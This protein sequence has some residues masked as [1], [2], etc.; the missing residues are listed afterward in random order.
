MN[1]STE[2]QTLQYMLFI[3]RLCY[4]LVIPRL[5]YPVNAGFCHYL[6]VSEI[7]YIPNSLM[8][9][10]PAQ[11]DRW[12]VSFWFMPGRLS[13]RIKLLKKAIKLEKSLLTQ[14]Q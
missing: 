13:P 12:S 9:F 8:N 14:N 11:E 2:L 5:C 6:F 10:R 4:W 1:T 7:Y 3:Y